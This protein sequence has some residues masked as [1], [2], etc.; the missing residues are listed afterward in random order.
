MQ[1]AVELGISRRSLSERYYNLSIDEK[2]VHKGH[3]YISILSDEQ[4]GTVIDVV[5]G[6][7]DDSVDELCQTALSEPQRKAVRTICSDMWQ[8]YIKE[9]KTYFSNALHGFISLAI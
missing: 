3:D 9:A 4:S 1:R 7:S 2:A 5:A 6:R 8:P